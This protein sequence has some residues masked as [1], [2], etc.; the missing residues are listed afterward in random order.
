MEVIKSTCTGSHEQLRLPAIV[1]R[2]NVERCSGNNECV[3]NYVE[4]TLITIGSVCRAYVHMSNLAVHING[5]ARVNPALPFY[6]TQHFT[7][8]VQP[9]TYT[10]GTVRRNRIISFCNAK[11]STLKQFHRYPTY[12]ACR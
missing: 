7:H 1:R 3:R 10:H 4:E 9:V 12:Y 6:L 11:Q 5:S 2:E 8:L